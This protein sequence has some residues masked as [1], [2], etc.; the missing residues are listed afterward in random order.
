MKN[1]IPILLLEGWFFL[2]F[3]LLGWFLIHT[4]GPLGGFLH[5]FL[6]VL[7][8]W[9][10]YAFVHYRYCRQE[11]LLHVLQTAAVTQAPLE[12]M[13]WAYLQDRP[14]EHLYRGI[15][16]TF[17][18]P[19]YYWIHVYRSFDAR[20]HRLATALESGVPLHAAI[21]LVPGIVPRELALAITIGEYTGKLAPSLRRLPDRRLMAQFLQLAPRL[22]YPLFVLTLLVNNIAFLM[23][24]IIPKFEKIFL[25]FKMR[26][27]AETEVLIHLSR[28]AGSL[29]L[30]LGLAWL[31]GLVLFNLLLFSS[32]VRWL[33]PGVN[34]VYR[35]Y[36]RGQFLQIL[37]AMMETGEPLPALLGRVLESG[38]LPTAVAMR[39]SAVAEE[40]SE[41]ESLADSLVRNGLL[42]T[43]MYGLVVSAQKANNLP[44]ALQEM[45]DSMIRR[46]AQ[47]SYRLTMILFPLGIVLCAALVAFVV[48]SIFT[49]L[50]SL[51]EA[52][53]G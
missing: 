32:R 42:P 9:E 33:C 18:F 2:G 20:L 43:S 27:P 1:A 13:L 6:F 36:A 14:R 19:G 52:M 49:P 50:I 25:D 46:S 51:L 12:S 30:I 37:G 48:V 40:Q 28:S 39:A 11:E 8:C 24:F 5:L 44:W 21:R 16:L 23:I 53:H 10:I 45:G 17:V 47:L 7:W 22:M 29:P 41:G 38:L 34:W 35:L 31:L 3:P 26:L 4:L 15:L